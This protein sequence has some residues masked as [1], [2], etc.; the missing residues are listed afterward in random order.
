MKEIILDE[1]IG[2]DP[3]AAVGLDDLFDNLQRFYEFAERA[4]R[5][6]LLVPAPPAAGRSTDRKALLT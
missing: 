2:L 4:D 3:V 6:A 5:T 1:Q